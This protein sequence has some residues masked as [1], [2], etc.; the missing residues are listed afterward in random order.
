[1]LSVS[2]SIPSWLK[3]SLYRNGPGKYRFGPDEGVHLFDGMA[4]LHHYSIENGRVTYH[5]RLLN[6]DT[7]KRNMA[8]NRI[9]MTEFG[10]VGHPDPC[11]SLFTRS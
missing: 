1:M 7:Y 5:N 8:A 6:S 11:K 9:V 3:G 10:V 4:V 2:G